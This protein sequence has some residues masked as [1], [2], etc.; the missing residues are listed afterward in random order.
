MVARYSHATGPYL[1][2][3][4]V[5]TVN[6]FSKKNLH[7]RQLE[8]MDEPV[9]HICHEATPAAPCLAGGLLNGTGSGTKIYCF[10]LRAH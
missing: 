8:A 7:K 9:T 10:A 1:Q 4:L 5:P 2:D 3:S 6:I